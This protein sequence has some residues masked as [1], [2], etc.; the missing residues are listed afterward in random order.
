MRRPP[1]SNGSA[2]CSLLRLILP[3]VL[4]LTCLP[5]VA[6]LPLPLHTPSQSLH[7]PLLPLSSLNL[8]SFTSL[9]HT[10]HTA[11]CR[12]GTARRHRSFYPDTVLCKRILPPPS[13]LA[14]VPTATLAPGAW[15]CLPEGP[16]AALVAVRAP[17]ITCT[18]IG[19]SLVDVGTCEL[20]YRLDFRGGVLAAV[21]AAAAGLFFGSFALA[22]HASL[23]ALRRSY[24]RGTEQRRQR[25]KELNQLQLRESF[26]GRIDDQHQ[27]LLDDSDRGEA[28]E[29]FQGYG[30]Y[31]RMIVRNVSE[32]S[33]HFS[34]AAPTPPS[35]PPLG[36]WKP[37]ASPPVG[38]QLGPAF[39]GSAVGSPSGSEFWTQSAS[40]P[41]APSG[42]GC[43][44]EPDSSGIVMPSPLGN[45]CV[46]AGSV[47][48]ASA[49]GRY[50]VLNAGSFTGAPLAPGD[51][52]A[53]ECPRS[54]ARM[55]P[56]TTRSL[57]E[58]ETREE[59]AGRTR[60]NKGRLRP[61]G[62]DR[63]AELV[64]ELFY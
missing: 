22:T 37:A 30:S 12:G 17:R 52:S 64:A 7:A 31:A 62:E 26:R 59:Q 21:A 15:A 43:R 38:D 3:S 39:W 36:S 40:S 34:S 19:P 46:V 53:A 13:A 47:V 63:T 29:R 18:R 41:L 42:S 8:L 44:G 6:P 4:A 50:P 58:R 28:V 2:P 60:R 55:D 5:P 33:L 25:R 20:R 57:N 32:A 54:L 48:D 56:G 45:S 14:Q 10:P 11:H 51:F 35:S 16:R 1:G 27:S 9:G 23:V 61:V 49:M 24:S